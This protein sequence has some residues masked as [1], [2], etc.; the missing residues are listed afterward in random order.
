FTWNIVSCDEPDTAWCRDYAA[1]GTPLVDWHVHLRGGMNVAKALQRTEQTTIRC[2]VLENHGRYWP[3]SN[4]D[5]LKAFIAANQKV[6]AA[7]GKTQGKDV[8]LGLQVND[9]DWFATIDENLFAQ[10]D[11][12]LADTMIMDKG[13]DGRP[14]KLWLLN[15]DHKVNPELWMERYVRHCEQVLDEPIDILAN[16][17][18]LPPFVAGMRDKLWTPERM[19]RIISKAV[20][21]GIALEI[22]AESAFPDEVFVKLAKSMGAKFSV[23][24]NNF[25]DKLKDLTKWNAFIRSCGLTS[26]DF[27]TV[28]NS[29]EARLAKFRAKRKQYE[30][31]EKIV[32]STDSFILE[33]N[34]S[35]QVVAFIDRRT[36]T[37]YLGAATPPPFCLLEQVR[38]KYIPT[39]SVKQKGDLLEFYFAN[40]ASTVLKTKRFSKWITVE[41]VSLE[42]P[43]ANKPYSLLFGRVPLGI[44][45]SRKNSFAASALI[46]TIQTNIADLPG[47]STMLGGRCYTEIG[48][49]GAKIAMLAAPQDQLRATMKEIL[50]D[51]MDQAEKD[52]KIAQSL[53]VVSRAGGP[54]AMDIE[55][56]RDN[57][58]IVYDPISIDN[59]PAYAEH[60]AKFGV[61]QVDFHQGTT[62]CTGDFVFNSKEYPGGSA[63]FKKVSEAFNKRG[64]ITGL[65]C[66]STFFPYRK[67]GY[68]HSDA[69]P[70]ASRYVTPVPSPDLADVR[71][72][73]LAADLS[74]DAVEVPVLE[75]TKDISTQTGYLIWNSTILRID[76]ELIEFKDV[77][78]EGAPGFVSCTRGALGTQKATHA[79]GAK[80]H[81]LGTYFSYYMTPRPGSELYFKVARDTAKAYNEGGFGMIYFDA[82]DGNDS[83]VSNPD[84]I[85]YYDALF[86]REILRNIKT[87]PPLMEYSTMFPSLWASRSRMGAWD[88]VSRCYS[89]LFDMHVKS[90]LASATRRFLPGQ[91]GWFVPAPAG[92]H[93]KNGSIQIFH[94]EFAEYLGAKTL[95]HDFGM[96]YAYIA[97]GKTSPRSFETGAILNKYNALRKR[98]YFDES[99]LKIIAE[100]QKHFILKSDNKT[101]QHYFIRAEY[102]CVELHDTQGTFNVTNSFATQ[103]SGFVRVENRYSAG[104][105]DAKN[106]VLVMANDEKAVPKN[107]MTQTFEPPIDLSKHYALGIWVYGDAKGQLIN[108]RTVC[109][110]SPPVAQDDYYIKVDFTGWKYFQFVEPHYGEYYDHKW[111][112]PSNYSAVFRRGVYRKAIANA[113]IMIEGDASGLRFRPLVAMQSI[114]TSLVNPIITIGGQTLRFEG[115]IKS[116]DC[117]EYTP[118]GHAFI[119]DGSGKVFGEMKVTGD[120]QTFASGVNKVTVEAQTK[121]GTIPSSRWTWQFTGDRIENQAKAK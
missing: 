62:Y 67:S 46:M 2:G 98:N 82:F 68:W 78:R 89:R 50:G 21:N 103:K 23:G 9:R 87:T 101:D 32:L 58:V 63:D 14:A 13:T 66:Y 20:A 39:T 12:I 88:A 35:G 94:P 53:P 1:K 24:T 79:K 91:M 117:M 36:G 102:P 92:G 108:I 86:I 4:N 105:Y 27:L 112:I 44:D 40:G 118:G 18:Y 61:D 99:V 60:F 7:R 93:I 10:L 95:A 42:S 52:P 104:P 113:Y 34:R 109:P 28:P 19:K 25:D 83:A 74:A 51:L 22:Q 57:Y 47:L 90:N 116:G 77:R 56:N 15:D 29:R 76:Q 110:P 38:R 48:C 73:T 8:C 106:N 111:P 75:E 11:F 71:E 54:F 17:T 5:R 43:E 72:L 41:V 81:H 33:L 59:V 6:I 30:A 119:R 55:K 115:E 120:F 16:P 80:V 49:Q 121:G 64:I 3:L 85:W 37:N 45:Y 97:P 96:S 100:P 31:E 70:A 107:L 114:S 65:H 69:T 84:L 26:S